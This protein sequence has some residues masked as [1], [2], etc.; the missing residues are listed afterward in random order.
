MTDKNDSVT[1][2]RGAAFRREWCDRRKRAFFTRD[3]Q[4]AHLRVP[5]DGEKDY[6]ETQ[7]S[8]LKD[9]AGHGGALISRPA[10]INRKKNGDLR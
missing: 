2:K 6:A 10:G 1:P 5:Y 3:E 7:C 9:G 8:P 4:I